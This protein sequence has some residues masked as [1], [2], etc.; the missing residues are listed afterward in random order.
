MTRGDCSRL[1]AIPLLVF[2]PLFGGQR[3]SGE[4]AKERGWFCCAASVG[5]ALEK[6][7]RN[8]ISIGGLNLAYVFQVW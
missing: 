1:G 6:R 5:D 3:L 2:V 7:K 8:S 4:P